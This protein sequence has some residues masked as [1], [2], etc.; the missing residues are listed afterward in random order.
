MA[1]RERDRRSVALTLAPKLLRL[2]DQ[3]VDFR[4]RQVLSAAPIGVWNLGRWGHR[5]FPKTMFGA[6]SAV[7][8]YAAAS[9]LQRYMNFW[10]Q[11]VARSLRRRNLVQRRKLFCRQS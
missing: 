10:I 5:T 11:L 3:P 1:L 9:T 2:G 8:L 6:S 4:R 7:V